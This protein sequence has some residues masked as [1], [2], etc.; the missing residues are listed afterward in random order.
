MHHA[1]ASYIAMHMH[2]INRKSV[3]ITEPM[4]HYVEMNAWALRQGC[5]GAMFSD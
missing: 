3:A 1:S 4:C 5:H 2:H